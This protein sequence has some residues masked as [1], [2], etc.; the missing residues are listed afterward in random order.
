MISN[1]PS[2]DSDKPNFNTGRNPVDTGIQKIMPEFG[3]IRLPWP[4]SDGT[5]LDLRP[6][7]RDPGFWPDASVLAGKL[8]IYI[9]I[10]FTLIYFMLRIKFNFYIL[11]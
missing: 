9:Y 4:D 7:G 11:I 6:F 10:Y 1:Q 8:L 3:D 5:V 2:S